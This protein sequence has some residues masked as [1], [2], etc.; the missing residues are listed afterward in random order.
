MYENKIVRDF[1]NGNVTK[2]EVD[3]LSTCEQCRK[4]YEENIIF[5]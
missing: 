4:S 2:A 1:E 5:K 3:A